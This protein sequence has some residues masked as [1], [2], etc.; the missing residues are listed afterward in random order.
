MSSHREA[1]EIS[2]DPAVDS[3]DVYAFV[4]PDKPDLV[5]LIANYIPFQDPAG[6]PN[7]FEFADDAIY[8]INVQNVGAK[9]IPDIVFEFRFTTAGDQPGHVPVQ[10]RPGDGPD[11][12]DAQPSPDVHADDEEASPDHDAW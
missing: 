5:T 9:A 10:H 7:F 1:P 6:G 8:R 12:R 3:T 2:R 4:S 11:R